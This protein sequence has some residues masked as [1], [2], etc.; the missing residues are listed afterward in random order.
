MGCRSGFSW[1]S[2]VVLGGFWGREV[3]VVVVVVMEEEEEEGWALR[4]GQEEEGR[5]VRE[6]QE[7]M[8]VEVDVVVVVV[9]GWAIV[10]AVAVEEDAVGG[11]EAA[12]GEAWSKNLGRFLCPP[13][14]SFFS[15]PPP[16]PPPGP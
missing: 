2:R 5:A 1:N 16:P 13:H 12:V 3:V 8:A 4:E 11:W 14:R 6:G 9:E 10:D 15:P 7:V